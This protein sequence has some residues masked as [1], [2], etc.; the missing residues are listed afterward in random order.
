MPFL[1]HV[2]VL[3]W[4]IIRSLIVMALFSAFMFVNKS[5]VFDTLIF[6]P[7]RPDFFTYRALCWIS[8]RIALGKALCIQAFDFRFINIELAAQFMVHI[9]MSI[10]AGFVASFPYV[11][12]EFWR[13]VR[14]ALYEHEASYARGIIFFSSLLFFSGVLFGYFILVPTM[15]NFLGNYQVS[16]N[17]ENSFT[18][19]NYVGFIGMFVLLSGLIFE[20]PMVVYFLSKIG[21][22]GPSLMRT[23]RRHAI[24]IIL[25]ISAIITPSP[26]IGSQI[27]VFLPVYFLYE[28]SIFISARVEKN[29][30]ATL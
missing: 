17:V 16:A 12:W 7:S 2:E 22:I 3:R 30:V 14:P 27:L 18:L 13:F 8:E 9:K 23:Y 6:G 1:D 20:L 5:F 19:T 10:L 25:F 11:F 28:I 29:R 4:H 26:D 21:L 15:L 24:V